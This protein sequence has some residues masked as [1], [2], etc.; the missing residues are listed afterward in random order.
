MLNLKP[1]SLLLEGTAM[2]YNAF[3]VVSSLEPVYVQALA[4]V[5]GAHSLF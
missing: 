4:R 5:A 2:F 3:E 1:A